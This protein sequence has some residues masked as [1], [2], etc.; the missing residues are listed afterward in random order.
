[1]HAVDQC[2]DIILLTETWCNANMLDLALAIPGYQSET[3]L[4]TDMRDTTNGL[5]GGLLVYSKLGLK[6]DHVTSSKRTNSISSVVST[7]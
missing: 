2:P 4:R 1:M 3:D 6:F 7:C 5:G